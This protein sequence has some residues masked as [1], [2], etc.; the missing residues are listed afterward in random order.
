M[1]E[2]KDEADM[3]NRAKSDFRASMSHELR[4]P[5]NAIIGFSD[6]IQNRVLGPEAGDNYTQYASDIHQSG[7]HLLGL[8][9]DILDLSKIE[10]GKFLLDEEDNDVSDLVNSALRLVEQRMAEKGL[11]LRIDLPGDLPHLRA[12]PG[13]VQ[14]MLINLLT[15]SAEFTPAGGS[16]AVQAKINGE[17]QLTLS[18]TDTGVGIA[19]GDMALVMAPFGQAKNVNTRDFSG[20][21]L[22]IPIVQSLIELH[23]GSLVLESEPGT[24]TTASL[25]FP[26]GRTVQDG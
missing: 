16:V 18:V 21:G 6:I 13:A 7:R 10:A 11:A 2:A 23:G 17:R 9:N 1:I 3:A 12:D 5:L 4:S 24:G 14:Q 26:P 19:P 8:I 20:T 15:N 25:H 22:G